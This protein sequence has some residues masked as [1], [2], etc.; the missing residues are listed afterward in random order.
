[1]LFA[2]RI[3]ESLRLAIEATQRR[4]Q[5]QMEF[6]RIH[7]ITPKSVSRKIES[8]LRDLDPLAE[9]NP[10]L[11]LI[12]EADPAGAEH[13]SVVI[14]S[15]N[16]PQSKTSQSSSAQPIRDDPAEW[17]SLMMAAAARLDFEEAAR[18]RDKLL[19]LQRNKG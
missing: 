11:N 18:W 17:E 10:D 1:L 9:Q 12:P 2:D 6:N 14:A 7:G 3:T 19:A 13:N 8:E 16:T 5:T 15:K 4:R